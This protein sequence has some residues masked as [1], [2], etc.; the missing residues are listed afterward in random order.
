[1]GFWI[2]MTISNLLI[3][4]LMLLFAYIFIKHP[5]KSINSIYGYRTSMSKKNQDTWDFAH[6]YCGK[7]WKKIGCIMMPFSVILMLPVTN[8]DMDM[9]GVVGA[10]IEIVE[11]IVL[12]AS[13]YPVEKA[14]KKNFDKDG[15]RRQMEQL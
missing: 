12:I 9:V 5:P 11:C 13:I 15:N 4:A 14:L 10:V 7:L 2:F 3:P 1:M 6:A 8:K